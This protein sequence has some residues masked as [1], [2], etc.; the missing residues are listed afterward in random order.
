M[1]MLIEKHLTPE[2]DGAFLQEESEMAGEVETPSEP[3]PLRNIELS[4]A[5]VGERPEVEYSIL[6]CKRVQS[7]TIPDRT[8]LQYRN[9]V[10]PRRQGPLVFALPITIPISSNC[11][12][13]YQN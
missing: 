3:P 5:L 6:K 11:F 7:H 1:L 8:K 4:S 12:S 9:T 10:R 13:Y 2:D